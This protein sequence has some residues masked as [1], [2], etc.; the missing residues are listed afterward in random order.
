MELKEPF[1]LQDLLKELLLAEKLYG[2]EQN[3][4]V[5]PY[6]VPLVQ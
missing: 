4:R 3:G 5:E 1:K 6:Q 2:E